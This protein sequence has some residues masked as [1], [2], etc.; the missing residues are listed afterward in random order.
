MTILSWI[1]L[2]NKIMSLKNLEKKWMHAIPINSAINFQ[3]CF[4]PLFNICPA[5]KLQFCTILKAHRGGDH[6]CDI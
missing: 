4:A 6:I 3:C 5:Y 1:M 2:E